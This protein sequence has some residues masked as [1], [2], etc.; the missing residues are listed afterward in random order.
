MENE[1]WEI[2]LASLEREELLCA[3]Q[4]VVVS[5][6]VE[7]W[8]GST[9]QHQDN[10][11]EADSALCLQTGVWYVWIGV[12]DSPLETKMMNSLKPSQPIYHTQGKH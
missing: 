7:L 6:L 8:N 10:C 1:I 4:V 11:S 5:H 2:Q 9:V 3:I 12:P